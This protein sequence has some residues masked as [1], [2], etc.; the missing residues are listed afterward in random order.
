M[1]T[2]SKLYCDIFISTIWNALVKHYDSA[3]MLDLSGLFELWSLS[4]LVCSGNVD[5][6][7]LLSTEK[8]WRC[9]IGSEHHQPDGRR[10]SLLEPASATCLTAWW[11]S[12]SIGCRDLHV[13]I[14]AS[15]SA[16]SASRR[17]VSIRMRFRGSVPEAPLSVWQRAALVLRWLRCC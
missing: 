13:T 3:C 7:T 16:A 12:P 2:W 1:F 10:C 15:V 9:R 17:R 14:D 8:T 4:I 11:S 6:T 5:G